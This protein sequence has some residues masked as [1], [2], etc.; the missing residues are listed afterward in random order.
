[1]LCRVHEIKHAYIPALVRIYILAQV[2][3]ELINLIECPI[4]VAVACA[5]LVHLGRVRFADGPL[6]AEASSWTITLAYMYRFILA[7][8]GLKR[9]TWMLS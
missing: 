8:L 2:H 6:C 4:G 1:M 3:E 5:H 7:W 9:C